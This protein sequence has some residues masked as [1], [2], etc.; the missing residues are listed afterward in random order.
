MISTAPEL[1]VAVTPSDLLERVRAERT[2]ADRAEAAIVELAV[3]WAHAHPAL[4]GDES[5]RVTTVT[6][7]LEDPGFA[8]EDELETFGIPEV[9]WAAPA[10]FAAANGMST[11]AGKYLLRDALILRHRLPRI[12]GRVV[13]GRVQAWR[14]RRIAQAVLGAPVDVVAHIDATLAEIAHKVGPVTLSRLLDEAM[15]ELHAEELEIARAEAMEQRHATIDDRS[16]SINGGLADLVIHGDWKDVHDFDQA[17]SRFAHL[18]KNTPEGEHESFDTLRA[19]AV[20]V[21][22]DPAYALALLNGEEAPTPG[23]QIV[24]YVHLT[25]A[26]LAGHHTVGR[27]E[28]TMRP[29]LEQQIRAWCGR[30][31][32]HL[33]VKPVIDLA[34]HTAVEAYEIPDR[35]AERVLLLQ[36]TCVFPWCTKSSRRCDCDHRVPFAVG[37]PTCECNLTP[38]CRHHHRLKTHAGWRYTRVEPGVYLWTDPHHQR[39]LRDREGTTDLTDDR[40]LLFGYGKYRTSPAAARALGHQP[41]A[42]AVRT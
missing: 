27:N 28:T 40:H 1:D 24:L 16:A 23:K 38:L 2:I 11:A 12:Y 3:E 13:T 42:G 6:N 33:S 22:A 29:V 21:L 30:T 35:L 18:L 25:D 26:A 41:V 4:P 31:D 9:H 8:D 17:L 19:R 14:A 5:W 15:L 36:P 34:D 20:G 10:A 32:T 39:F 7:F 37:G